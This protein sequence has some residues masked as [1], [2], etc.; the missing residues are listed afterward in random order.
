MATKCGYETEALQR[1]PF[2]KGILIISF[3]AVPVIMPF[4]PV[5]VIMP[6][7]PVPDII[8]FVPVLVI[9]SFVFFT[10]I[11]VVI[12]LTL[13]TGGVKAAASACRKGGA[14]LR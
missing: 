5:S 10:L 2:H 6:F 4:V 8:S 3:I 11:P 12:A 1:L 9:I 7:V 13:I 14:G